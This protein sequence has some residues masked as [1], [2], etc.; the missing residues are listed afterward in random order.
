MSFLIQK[1]YDSVEDVIIDELYT[2]S[3]VDREIHGTKYR[4]KI[5]PRVQSYLKAASPLTENALRSQD[6]QGNKLIGRHDNLRADIKN[7][8]YKYETITNVEESNLVASIILSDLLKSFSRHK[9][10]ERYFHENEQHIFTKINEAK[11]NSPDFFEIFRVEAE[12]LNCLNKGLNAKQSYIEGFN[13]G[14]SEHPEYLFHFSKFLMNNSG[15]QGQVDCLSN[16]QA[17]LKLDPDSHDVWLELCRAIMF[18]G[19]HADSRNE[20]FNILNSQTNLPKSVIIRACALL[21]ESYKRQLRL[22]TPDNFLVLIEEQLSAYYLL[23]R[24]I[25]ET[26]HNI[27]K[28]FDTAKE[29]IN[30]FENKL[31][32]RFDLNRLQVV[33]DSIDSLLRVNSQSNIYKIIGFKNASR[34]TAESIKNSSI[35][36]ELSSE[37]WDGLFPLELIVI[38]ELIIQGGNKKYKR[39]NRLEG[40]DNLFNE[41]VP[42]VITHKNMDREILIALQEN[43]I[44][45]EVEPKYGKGKFERELFIGEPILIFNSKRSKSVEIKAQDL[46]SL[47]SIIETTSNSIGNV[48][49]ESKV[50]QSLVG[51]IKS[52]RADKGFAF[53]TSSNEDFFLHLSKSKRLDFDNLEV[54]NQVKFIP[55]YNNKASE[56]PSAIDALKLETNVPRELK[57]KKTSAK[58]KVLKAIRKHGKVS[59]INDSIIFI[60]SSSG[61]FIALKADVKEW[62]E[63]KKG[64]EVWFSIKNQIDQKNNK[65]TSINIIR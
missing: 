51:V 61:S 30:E 29:K 38:G 14:G 19:D 48:K 16:L 43:G 5:K 57:V 35:K 55:V 34:V 31:S 56:K 28:N 37:Q 47:I 7:V 17:A 12:A 44:M 1:P 21:L 22:S 23:P 36:V 33:K 10:N 62:G 63:I 3:L 18:K 13:K 54:G 40:I 6:R 46:S 15:V 65:A 24:T 52:I 60:E 42:A 50:P 26:R 59:N 41:V 8:P 45:V 11:K 49:A 2:R 27:T 39:F 32:D 53:V 64:Q 20:I 25:R 58:K 9:K 4:I